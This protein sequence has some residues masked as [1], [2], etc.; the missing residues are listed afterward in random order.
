MKTWGSFDSDLFKFKMST[1]NVKR[2]EFCYAGYWTATLNLDTGV[3][4]QCYCGKYIQ[5]IFKDLDKPIQWQAIGCH[6][7]EPHCHNS[8]VWLTL[9]DIPSLD[10]PT[11]SSM[12]NRV[13]E[14]GSEWLQPEMKEFLSGKLKDNNTEF[15]NDRAGKQEMAA[16]RKTYAANR[17]LIIFARDSKSFQEM[18]RVFPGTHIEMCPDIVFSL[19]GTVSAESRNGIG[20]CMRDDKEKTISSEQTKKIIEQLSGNKAE[21][22][23]FDTAV[24]AEK[25]IIGEYRE[26]LVLLSMRG[27][28]S[29]RWKSEI[30]RRI[31]AT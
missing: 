29:G 9:G 6:C 2:K 4:R 16:A 25:P 5:N 31:S 22:R 14:D 1:F 20:V 26:K 7:T 23:Q 27:L 28:L 3:L 21:I 11:Y 10:T 19:N 24:N 30:S 12:R 15:S 8:H 17:N 13:C 18:K